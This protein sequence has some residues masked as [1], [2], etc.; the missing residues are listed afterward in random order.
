MLGYYIFLAWKSIRRTPG[1]S[2][3]VVVCIA[4]GV[5]VATLFSAIWQTY[6]KDPIPEKSG[7]LYYVRMDNW[8]PQTP[9]F[10][11]IPPHT[12]YRDMIGIMKSTVPVRQTGTYI[13]TFHIEK[14]EDKATPLVE[15]GRVCHADFFPMFGLEFRFGS[16]WSREA[17]EKADQLVVLGDELNQTL[18]HGENSVGRTL[19]LEGREFRVAGV[20]APV[21]RTIRYYDLAGGQSFVFEQLFISMAHVLPMEILK[22]GPGIGWGNPKKPGFAG[23]LLTG[24]WNFIGMWVELSDS[25][26]VAAYHHFLDGYALE[27]RIDGR[28]LRP[29]DNRITPM[30]EYMKEYRCPPPEATAMMITGNLFHA[31]C[32]LSLMG[33]LL[34][35]FLSRT[36]EIGTRRALGASR[37]TIFAQHL[38]EGELLG[39][40]GGTLG[41]VLVA[42]G[43][44]LVDVWYTANTADRPAIVFALN[45]RM[46]IFS[47]VVSLVAGILASIYPAYRVCRLAPASHMKVQ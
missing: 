22:S 47:V 13:A 21:E 43:L 28:F 5:M 38:V 30:R 39:L 36:A 31:A 45:P 11:G 40:L 12:T 6:A 2:L 33:L 7:H 24:E 46:A 4:L 44:R 25:E 3:I 15:I 20:L 27:Q 1:N 35:R 41:L 9:H 8:D 14:V 29:L 19:R 17:D 26:S 32:A 34:S 37:W 23:S 16:A 18:F 10:E 42:V